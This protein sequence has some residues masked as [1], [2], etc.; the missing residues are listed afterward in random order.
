M[1]YKMEQIEAIAAKLRGLPK[2]EKEKLWHGKQEA[3]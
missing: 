3:I 1:K 2:V